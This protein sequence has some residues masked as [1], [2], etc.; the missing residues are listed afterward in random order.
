MP[1]PSLPSS[2]R[3]VTCRP[4]SAHFQSFFTKNSTAKKP[5]AVPSPPA[6]LS[7]RPSTHTPPSLPFPKTHVQALKTS[8]AGSLPLAKT[9]AKV[10]AA[11]SLDASLFDHLA[12]GTTPHYSHTNLL[13]ASK[14]DPDIV[15]HTRSRNSFFH[16]RNAS[17][18]KYG[19]LT[20]TID[21]THHRLPS[22]PL[23]PPSLFHFQ[24][25][26]RPRSTL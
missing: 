10:S 20:Y 24:A 15:L 25:P 1:V 18:P 23:L 26:T 6:P 19:V 7:L 16:T 22:H 11:Q 12:H 4:F 3:C 17:M 5:T 14:T 8:S 9:A 2:S 13:N 21:L